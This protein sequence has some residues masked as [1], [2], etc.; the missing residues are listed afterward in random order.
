MHLLYYLLIYRYIYVLLLYTSI[1]PA[2]LIKSLSLFSFPPL[3]FG[4]PVFPPTPWLGYRPPKKIV[5]SS[6]PA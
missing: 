3:S 5:D 6:V 2:T 4:V 1:L